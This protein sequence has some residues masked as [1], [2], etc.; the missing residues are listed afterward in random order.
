[1]FCSDIILAEERD[2]A[3]GFRDFSIFKGATRH[4]EGMFADIA[5]SN[6]A[7]GLNGPLESQ[8]TRM[9][10]FLRRRES[11][12]V[13]YV[14]GRAPAGITDIISS[15][16]NLSTYAGRHKFTGHSGQLFCRYSC[17]CV[18]SVI[19]PLS[20]SAARHQA[21]VIAGWQER[22]TRPVVV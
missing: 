21:K 5:A 4:A 6:C 14:T 11:A 20:A 7:S 13:Y 9:L 10:V 22:L 16:G 1:M 19:T 18:L 3:M 8:I 2:F 15:R 17:S 12:F